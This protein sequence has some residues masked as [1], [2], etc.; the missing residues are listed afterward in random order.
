MNNKLFISELNLF[1][2]ID[3][4]LKT[5]DKDTEDMRRMIYE[6]LADYIKLRRSIL[7]DYIDIIFTKVSQ[8]F[9]AEQ[10]N[11]PKEAA[12][13]VLIRLVK[14]IDQKEIV[15]ECIK[16]K[17]LTEFLIKQ[18]KMFKPVPT[19]RGSIWH[20]LA[21]IYSR[22]PDS[23]N[24][25]VKKDI[26]ETLMKE[27]ETTISSD[28]NLQTISKMVKALNETLHDNY[29]S[30]ALVTKLYNFL[31]VLSIPLKDTYDVPKSALKTLARHV[32]FFHTHIMNTAKETFELC[33]GLMS[34]SNRDLK[35][36]ATEALE[37]VTLEM[38]SGISA[39]PAKYEVL[40]NQIIEKLWDIIR[41]R[42]SQL[43]I[44][45]QRK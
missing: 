27:L 4:N 30:P 5:S 37:A 43:T 28:K 31:T 7:I 20:L 34:H 15:Q 24:R 41:N 45:Q 26:Q 13:R 33:L 40:Y 22:Y 38:V 18:L 10:A 11:K 8:Y 2:Y 23:I 39:E 6:L 25:E 21:L 12:L 36:S 9:A 35:N 19:V 17:E 1:G 3:Q 32:Q 16:P 44:E 14:Y 42:N 29:L